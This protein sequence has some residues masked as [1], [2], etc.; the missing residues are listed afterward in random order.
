MPAQEIGGDFVNRGAENKQI[1]NYFPLTFAIF[2][3]HSFNQTDPAMC[4]TMKYILE[5]IFRR[6]A[7]CER[8]K[9]D[10]LPENKQ[11]IPNCGFVLLLLCSSYLPQSQLSIRKILIIMF[12]RRSWHYHNNGS[13]IEHFLDPALRN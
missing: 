3:L 6:S 10:L 7:L 8:G 9:R 11:T 13:F 2:L 4:Y 12:I 5:D 1:G